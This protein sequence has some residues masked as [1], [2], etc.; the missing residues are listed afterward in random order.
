M[1]SS[2]KKSLIIFA[3]GSIL[4]ACVFFLF[5]INLFD[6]VII[7]QRG[8]QTITHERPLS[9]SYFIGLGYEESDMI[10][11]KDFYLKPKGILMAFLFI[12]GFPAILAYRSYLK[13]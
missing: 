2:I 10:G 3:V 4:L 11:I 8:I 9:L 5:P 12:F 7:E 6:G 1:S 13:D